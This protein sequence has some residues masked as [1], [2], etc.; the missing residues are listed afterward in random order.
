MKRILALI[1]M[2]MILAS[3]SVFACEGKDKT[4]VETEKPASEQN[5]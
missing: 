2:V 1:S 4:K 5:I 3:A